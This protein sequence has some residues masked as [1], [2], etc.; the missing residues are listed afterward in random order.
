M[1]FRPETKI[2]L[3]SLVIALIM[4][5]LSINNAAPGLSFAATGSESLPIASMSTRQTD[6]SGDY[7]SSPSASDSRVSTDDHMTSYHK[8]ATNEFSVQYMP[9]YEFVAQFA[10]NEQF[11]NP[12]ITIDEQTGNVFVADYFNNRVIKFDSSGNVITQWGIQGSADGEFINP[13]D[14]GLDSA[15]FVYVVDTRN[16]RIQKF[17][18]DGQFISKWGNQGSA[19][20]EFNFPDRIAIDSNN[21]VYVTDDGNGRV[22]KFTTSGQFV[23]KFGENYLNVPVGI[24]VDTSDNVYVAE[25]GGN[26][27]SK[28]NSAGQFVTSWGSSGSLDGQLNQPKGLHIDSQD[29]VFVADEFNDRVQVF[30]KDGNFITKF[31]GNMLGHPIDVAV[32]STGQVYVSN[33]NTGDILIY[34]LAVTAPTIPELIDIINGMGI[35]SSNALINPLQQICKDLGMFLSKVGLYESSGKLTAQ[36][37]EE[38]RH[39]GLALKNKLAC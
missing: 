7:S 37:A 12:D 26:R 18:D 22:Q 35:K 27:I 9:E 4:A 11:G 1:A 34:A 13:Q 6:S 17:T 19:D 15:G 3:S 10:P 36:Q 2:T 24:D 31:N 5:S 16:H 25:S 32:D 20:G 28:F 38:L 8:A 33:E 30:D 21:F 14:V 23:G 39:L 29:N